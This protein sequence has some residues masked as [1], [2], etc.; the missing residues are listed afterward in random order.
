MKEPFQLDHFLKSCIAEHGFSHGEWNNLSF[1]VT[2]ECY[3]NWI[4][5]GC[6][7]EMAYLEKHAPFKKNPS[8]RYPFLKS[9][10]SFAQSYF[11]DIPGATAFNESSDGLRIALYAKGN[12]YHFW[13][14]EKLQKVCDE[15]SKYFPGEI[16][17][18]AT[19]SQPLL[20]RDMAYRAG[21]GWFGKNTCLIH[22]KKGSLFFLGEILT[23]LEVEVSKAPLPDFCGTCTKCIDICPTQAL[24]SPKNL[25]AK[26]CISYWT[27]ESKSVPPPELR[28]KFGDHFFGCDLCQTICP[29]NEKIFKGKL[30]TRTV[31]HPSTE[32]RMNLI[33]KLRTL[34]LSSE[35]ELKTQWE[36]SPLLRAKS[37]G[38]KR[39]ALIVIGNLGLQELFKD[40]EKIQE[41]GLQELKNWTLKKLDA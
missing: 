21:L 29:W 14:K 27:I 13:F 22:P 9:Y 1:P 38:L 28:E 16:F 32:E 33:K 26:K 18:A 37:F 12:D 3:Q 8:S 24:T 36:L 34:L 41:H 2:Y 4:E 20:E 19:D 35:K 6:H 25:D 23:S 40:I 11:P 15:L 5:K 17:F 39:N 10:V 30:E 31:R 7:G